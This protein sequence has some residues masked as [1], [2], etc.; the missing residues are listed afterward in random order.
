VPWQRVLSSSGNISS[1]GP[2]TSGADDQRRALETEGVEVVQ[3]RTGEWRVDLRQYGWFPD[4]GAVTLPDLPGM[5]DDD[6]DL[7]DL[8]EDG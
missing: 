3:G 1:R 2:G 4:P 7:T 6:S 5:E 8:E